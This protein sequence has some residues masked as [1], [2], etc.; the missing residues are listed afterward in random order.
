[1]DGV[2]ALLQELTDAN[3][4]SGYEKEVRNIMR[5]RLAAYG[6]ISYDRLGSVICMQKGEADEPRIALVAHMDEVGFMVNRINPQGYIRFNPLGGWWSQVLLAQRVLINTGKGPVPG[7]IG[8]KP[9]HLLTRDELNRVVPFDDMFIDIG[10]T[11]KEETEKAGVRPGDPVAP[12]GPFTILADPQTYM[13]KAFD[14]RA[15][16]AM[17][18]SVLDNLSRL[19]HPN[20]VFGVGTVQEEVGLRGAVTS[21]DAVNPDAAIVLEVDAAGDTPDVKPRESSI[22]LGAG[23][24][25]LIYDVRMIP[26]LKFR[27]LMFD[28]AE[29]LKLPLQLS[30]A[31]QG[32]TD[33]GMI[34]IHK[35]GVPTVVLSIPV[36]YIHCNNSIMCRRDFD[37]AVALATQLVQD[38]DAATVAGLT[39]W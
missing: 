24:T 9:P 26:N 34:D 32:A 15:G 30:R 1:M 7:E 27:D 39:A 19:S 2:E 37:Q 31:Q 3:G 17:V 13:A 38:L 10:S 5:R 14:D 8:S 12:V 11:S 16:C 23:P 29:K 22:K 36:R 4:V 35:T 21:V 25:L 6:E 28:T 18:I 33:G 20:A